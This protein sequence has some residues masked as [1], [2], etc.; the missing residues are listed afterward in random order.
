LTNG[1]EKTR[2]FCSHP[3]VPL[4]ESN[5]AYRIAKLMAENFPKVYANLGGLIKVVSLLKTS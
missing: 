5:V 2:L 1:T 3:D 4:D